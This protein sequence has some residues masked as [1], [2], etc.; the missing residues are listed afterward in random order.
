MLFKTGLRH[1]YRY[2]LLTLVKYTTHTALAPATAAP[3][4]PLATAAGAYVMPREST[5]PHTHW[6]LLLLLQLNSQWRT[7]YQ[8]KFLEL[9]NWKTPLFAEHNTTFN[10]NVDIAFS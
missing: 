2:I 7:R 6:P 10:S 1:P 9:S 5:T 4:R 8:C 3:P